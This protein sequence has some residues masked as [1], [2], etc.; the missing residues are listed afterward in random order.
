M[1]VGN[2]GDVLI[3]ESMMHRLGYNSPNKALGQA[4]GVELLDGW[5]GI[6][7]VGIVK[8]YHHLGLKSEDNGLFFLQNIGFARRPDDF[9]IKL[10]NNR[11]RGET[12]KDIEKIF[13]ELYPNDLFSIKDLKTGFYKIYTQEIINQSVF[14]IFS[15]LAIILACIGVAGLASFTSRLKIGLRKLFG[16]SIKDLTWILSK[17]FLYILLGSILIVTPIIYYYMNNWL[18][19]Y[20]YRISLQLWH[21]SLS[22]TIVGCITLLIISFNLFK[23]LRKNPIKALEV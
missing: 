17:E 22:F 18:Q 4:L 19:E 9:S 15:I 14:S 1:K 5:K 2:H 10:N 11:P 7:I 23:T 16:A 6:N 12:I 13:K 21:F 8:D 20:P 3:S